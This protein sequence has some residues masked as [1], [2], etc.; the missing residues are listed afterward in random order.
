[1]F[2][3]GTGR[4]GL[5]FGRWPMSME[6]P[7]SSLRTTLLALLLVVSGILAASFSVP[8]ARATNGVAKDMTFLLHYVNSTGTAKPLP[9]GGSTL[10][11]FDTTLNFNSK[12]AMVLVSGTQKVLNWFLS[13][14]LAGSFGANASTLR[15][16]ANSSTSASSLAQVTLEI[17][18]MNATGSAQVSMTNLGSQS[19][20][21]TPTLKAW[22]A[23]FPSTHTFAAGSSIEVRLTVTPGVNQGVWFHYDTPQ[24]NSRVSF[25]GPNSLDIAGIATLDWALRPTSSFNPGA[26]NKTMYVQASLTDPLGGYD[27][28]WA[29]VTIYNPLGAIVVNNRSMAKVSGT[30]VDY[31]SPYQF[32]WNY[33]GQP[34]GIYTV[35]IWALDNNGYNWYFFFSQFTYD[36]YPAYRTGSFSIGSVFYVNI[37]VLDNASVP[38]AGAGVRATQLGQTVAGATTNALGRVNMTLGAGNYN[39]IVMWQ[40]IHAGSLSASIAANVSAA[41]PLVIK[42]AVYYPRFQVLDSHLV[43]LAGAA[44]TYT[45]PNGTTIASPLLT[46][47]N[48]TVSLSQM[49]GGNYNISVRWRGTQVARL[50]IN[51]NANAVFVIPATVY[52]V[53]IHVVDS[54]GL[55]VGFAGVVVKDNANGLVLDFQLTNVQGNITSR[56]PAGKVDV[57]AYLQDLLIGR[58]TGYA[59]SGDSSVNIQAQVYYV[60]LTLLDSQGK[61]VGQAEVAVKSPS[62]AVVGSGTSGSD[63]RVSLRLPVGTDDLSVTWLGTQVYHDAAFAVGGDRSVSLSL[64]VYHITAVVLDKDGHPLQG[65]IVGVS[66]VGSGPQLGYTNATGSAEFRV[67]RGSYNVTVRFVTTYYGTPVDI[68]KSQPSSVQGDSQVRIVLDAFAPP[69]YGTQVFEMGILFAVITAALLV[70]MLLLWRRSRPGKPGPAEPDVAGETSSRNVRTG[71][72]PSL[73]P[74]G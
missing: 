26:A 43:P 24:F 52:Y 27:I 1:M 58:L 56:L 47:G 4:S 41:N 30:P 9:G 20:P 66:A 44:L 17:F 3:R 64:A 51:V 70:L 29:N 62:G 14:A 48:G 57:E 21:V 38:L 18:E 71:P 22:S 54:R 6:N 32:K 37:L 15:V 36:S 63:G 68:T 39:F 61:A 13:P 74:R 45:H 55:G 53:S 35:G 11:Y 23:T 67:P 42:A 40:S 72:P 60:D 69:V 50:V 73:P 65:A 8:T 10:T 59:V 12:D 7:S 46:G 2:L 49:A 16:W 34:N 5:N 19:F 25:H 31:R 33:S 28:R